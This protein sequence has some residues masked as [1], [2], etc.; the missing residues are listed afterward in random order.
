MPSNSRARGES[1][2][3]FPLSDC[4]RIWLIDL[5]PSASLSLSHSHS[6]SPSFTIGVSVLF[7]PW[8]CP[9]ISWHHPH[10]S[11]ARITQAHAHQFRLLTRF[12]L[13]CKVC[14]HGENI[15]IH[16]CYSYY[17]FYII[18]KGF[19]YTRI[20]EYK[21]ISLTYAIDLYIT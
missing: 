11:T 6:P 3:V 14:A 9:A 8:S 2:R 1:M 10:P 15:I 17:S 13:G 18:N 5:R 4:L 12:K 19:A 20:L 21:N 16:S 7:A